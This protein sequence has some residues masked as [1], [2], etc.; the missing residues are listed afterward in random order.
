MTGER[1]RKLRIDA[2]LNLG[3]AARGMGIGLSLLSEWERGC[4][5]PNI[6]QVA[7]L[8]ETFGCTAEEIAAALP[9]DEEIAEHAG[10]VN[11]TLEKLG[12]ALE[13]VQ[14]DAKAQGFK[15]GNGGRG[16]VKCP[17]CEGGTLRYSVA[18]LNGHIWGACS[19]E[20]CVRWM[21]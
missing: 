1:L 2:G 8:A 16:S 9:T 6:T 17:C 21:Q 14:T 10:F 3:Q 19:T 11:S 5:K 13:S 15:R 12:K 4:G 7:L 18:G 20:G